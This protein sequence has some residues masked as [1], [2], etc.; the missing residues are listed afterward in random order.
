MMD[1]SSLKVLM[2]KE[3][4]EGRLLRWAKYL[5]EYDYKI[6]FWP[7][8][9][10]VLADMLSRNLNIQSIVE[11]KDSQ[12]AIR[13]GLIY[14]PKDQRKSLLLQVHR[15]NLSHLRFDKMYQFLWLRYYWE[16]MTKNIKK[17]EILFHMC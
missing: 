7:G 2:Q 4:L 5:Q 10:N 1:Y 16:E 11:S 12:E 17:I 13:Q 6:I 8:K 3:N 9:N 15:I 14:I